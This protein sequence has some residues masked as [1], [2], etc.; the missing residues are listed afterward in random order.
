M[1]GVRATS[2]LWHF[3]K[4]PRAAALYPSRSLR[5]TLQSK[6]LFQTGPGRAGPGRGVSWGTAAAAGFKPAAADYQDIYNN[7]SERV[8]VRDPTEISHQSQKVASAPPTQ[9]IPTISNILCAEESGGII[10]STATLFRTPGEHRPGF[11]GRAAKDSEERYGPSVLSVLL[12]VQSRQALQKV[13]TTFILPSHIPSLSPQAPL[14][15]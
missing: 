13:A 9:T 11:N 6:H 8:T 7:V 15:Y 2:P 10:R 1:V 12:H 5:H 3:S 14:S 4:Y